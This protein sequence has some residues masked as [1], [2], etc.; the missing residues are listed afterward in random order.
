MDSPALSRLLGSRQRHCRQISIA[1]TVDPLSLV[2][3]LQ[4]APVPSLPLQARTIEDLN[5][6]FPGDVRFRVAQDALY[7]FVLGS[8]FIQV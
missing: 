8:D 4:S 2:S 6:A 7:D 1:T 5:V 3:I